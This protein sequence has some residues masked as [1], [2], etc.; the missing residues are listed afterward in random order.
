MVT[1]AFFSPQS[2]M[3]YTVLVIQSAQG[4]GDNGEGE[5]EREM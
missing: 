3:E 4:W 5:R 2:I 1:S